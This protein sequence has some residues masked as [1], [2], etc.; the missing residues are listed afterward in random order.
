MHKALDRATIAILR[1]IH[2]A[3]LRRHGVSSLLARPDANPKLA[4]NQKLGVLGAPLHLA[5]AS[6]S[7]WNVCPMAT[8][9]CRAACLHTAGNPAH[10]KGK[11][12]ARIAKTRAYFSDRA[13]FMQA[14][15]FEVWRHEQSAKRKGFRRVS[16]RLNATSDL[17]WESVPVTLPN[18]ATFPHVMALFPRAVF[19]DYTKLH[20]RKGLPSNYSVTYSLADGNDAR[21]RQ[22]IEA[23]LNVAAV[24]A[25]TRGHPLPS[26]YTLD[27][28]RLRVIDG[29]LTDYRPSDPRGVIVGLR[30]KGKAIGDSSGFVR[31]AKMTESHKINRDS[32][33]ESISGSI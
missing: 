7:G 18:G 20:N 10:M 8:Q 28:L 2:K 1:A 22:A 24:F 15:V 23:G 9:G 25:V 14:L 6:L 19:Y 3:F 33:L 13:A 32:F 5:P 4:K 21:A 27:G 31:S 12:R 29:D 17:R 30:A 11:Q 26:H 16:L